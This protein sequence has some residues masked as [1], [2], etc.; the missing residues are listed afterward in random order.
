MIL[1]KKIMSFAG[2]V[3][4]TIVIDKVL[5]SKA[6]HDGAVKVMAKAINLKKAAE[7]TYESIKEDADDLAYEAREEARRQQEAA[8]VINE[9][10]VEA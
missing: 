8:E 4:S 1:N 10:P 5:K 9:D 2:G 3:A 6:V 7:E